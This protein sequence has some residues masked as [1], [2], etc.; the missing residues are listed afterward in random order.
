MRNTGIALALDMGDLKKALDQF[1]TALA[2][3]TQSGNRRQAVQAHLY[4]GE[5]LWRLGQMEKARQEFEAALAGARELRSS[6]DEWMA[7][8]G[9]GRIFEKAGEQPQALEHYRNAM[10][11]IESIRSRIGAAPLQAG[12]LANKR[13]VYDSMIGLLLESAIPQPGLVLRTIEGAKART[14]QDRIKKDPLKDATIASVAARLDAGTLLL[15]LWMGGE[16]S[17][18]VWITRS[19]SGIARLQAPNTAELESFGNEL[20]NGTG[21]GWRAAAGRISDRLVAPLTQQLSGAKQ[22]VIV[23]DGPLQRIPFEALPVSGS[24]HSPLL[25]EKLAVSYVPSVSA[26]K[27]AAASAARSLWPPWRRELV[28]FADPTLPPSK[29]DSLVRS[30]LVSL[31]ASREEVRSIA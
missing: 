1:N 31:P 3:A 24:P 5:T 14:F 18:A 22:L 19:G 27:P 12:F 25:I 6:E 16:K 4:L 2:M 28:A 11:T 20:A 10:A 7:L 17:A 9:L 26:I 30:R 13:D 23:P 15:D 21:D 29:A 8:Y